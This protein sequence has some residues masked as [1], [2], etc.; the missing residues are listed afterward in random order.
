MWLNYFW[1]NLNDEW[2]EH[3]LCN[4]TMVNYDSLREQIQQIDEKYPY[5]MPTWLIILITVLGTLIIGTVITGFLCCKLKHKPFQDFIFWYE[6]NPKATR[7]MIPGSSH[8]FIGSP[9]IEATPQNVRYT[10]ELLGIYFSSFDKYKAYR[11]SK[12]RRKVAATTVK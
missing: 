6:M 3:Y 11:N 2:L 12:D 9:K 8:K 10:L 5:S 4:Y 7:T 1:N